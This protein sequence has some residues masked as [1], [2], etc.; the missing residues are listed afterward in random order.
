MLNTKGHQLEQSLK[1]KNLLD[2]AVK[3]AQAIGEQIDGIRAPDEKLASTAKT[4]MDDIGAVRGRPLFFP[5]VGTGVGRGAYVELIDG[6]VKLDL[7]NG[8]GI[9]VLGHSHPR[10]MSAS[11]RGAL[12]DIVMQGNLEPN[13]EYH[14]ISKKLVDLASRNSRLKYVWLSTCGTMANENALKAC[15]QKKTPARMVIAMNAAFAGRSTMM[16]E[17]TDNPNFKVGLPEYNEVL[18]VPWFDKTDPNSSAKSLSVFKEHVAK[19]GQNIACFT[20]EPMQGEGG[21][22][23]A[24]REFFLPILEFCREHKI[25]VWADE[26]QTF[27][28]T[29]NFFAFETLGIGDFIDVCTIAKTAQNGATFYTEEFNPKPGL[30]SGTF[31]GST[32]S[33]AAGLEILNILDKENYMGPGGKIAMIHKEFVSM[34]EDLNSTTCKGLLQDAGGL[35]LMVAVTPMD[36]TKDKVDRLMHTL[37]KNGLIC[38]GCGKGPYKLRF[39]LPAILTSADINVAKGIIEKSIKEIS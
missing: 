35:G 31:S 20:F 28:R 32:V 5:F 39:L 23:V 30:I 4:V 11:L 26:V 25:P 19:H 12:S 15:R 24:P 33:L 8:I 6:S 2:E 34:L 16:A 7:I 38:F 37:Y 29:G 1:I 3:E 13:R 18:R 21:Y 22:N 9:H 17:I 36:G 27:T 14:L 10:V